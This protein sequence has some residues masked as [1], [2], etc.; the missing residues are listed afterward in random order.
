MKIGPKLIDQQPP[1]S[2]ST[3]VFAK[4]VVIGRAKTTVVIVIAPIYLKR[5]ISLLFQ[6][7]IL[8]CGIILI[9]TKLEPAG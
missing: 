7:N 8:S 5:L 6:I 4:L 2:G 1:A 9:D 3:S